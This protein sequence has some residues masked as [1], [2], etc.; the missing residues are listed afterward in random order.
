MFSKTLAGA[1][2]AALVGLATAATAAEAQVPITVTSS[3]N[4]GPGT[5]RAAINEANSNFSRSWIDFSLPAV[6]GTVITPAN[7][8]PAITSPL[9]IDG[10]TQPGASPAS[11]TAG[12]QPGVLIDAVNTTRALEITTGAS[13]IRGLA[14]HDSSGAAGGPDGIQITGNGN[15]IAGNHI[16]TDRT[17]IAMNF[18]NLTTGVDITG[19]RNTVGGSGPENANV[20]AAI[21]GDG[22]A[23]A[24]NRN[25]VVGNRLG[26]PYKGGLG[27]SSS[28]VSVT[29][30]ENRIGSLNT[31]HRN[32]ISKNS[33]D[34]VAIAGNRNIVEGNYVGL[35]ETGANGAG[36]NGDGVNVV[37]NENVVHGNTASDNSHG[38]FLDGTANTV[39]FNALGTNAK[40]TAAVPNFD[41]VRVWAGNFNVIGGADVSARNVISGN[42]DDGVEIMAGQANR[43]EGNRIGTN[44]DGVASLPNGNGVV[45]E[46]GFS[47]I[48]DNLVSGNT[49]AGVKL[50]GLGF[51]PPPTG[52]V[53]DGNEVAD[54]G[55][56][57][58]VEDSHNNAI[59]G[60]QISANLADGVLIEAVNLPNANGN[61]LTGNKIADNGLSGVRVKDADENLVGQPDHQVNTITGNGEDGVTVE[62]G[63]DNAVANNSISDN[64]DLGIDL[65]ADGAT[66]NDVL[67]DL[68]PGPNG[69]QNHPT[70]SGRSLV[71]ERL[72]ELPFV[73]SY[74]VVS[75]TLRSAASTDYRVELY[76][77]DA[78]DASG[79]GEAPELVATEQV[80][81][82]ATGLATGSVR[83]ET[84]SVSP[85]IAATATV[86]D[87]N[88]VVLGAS[89]ELSPCG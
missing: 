40:M 8:L 3:A 65:A 34:G 68:D 71:F 31:G 63:Q 67:L 87:P 75:W 41:G 49:S 29:G 30:N 35:D 88:G 16:G 5:L 27:N 81:T 74:T 23:I 52:N 82:D 64:G 80:T 89:S 20:I 9:E 79:R 57:V 69:L 37:G 44:G 76:G 10:Y 21:D 7:D 73:K 62:T 86:T 47:V 66:N 22:V 11:S 43:V 48:V 17:G 1:V 61:W 32:V 15:R 56:G 55:N 12:A 70:I 26:L 36:N 54:N 2:A 14:I 6:A 13:V 85:S 50:D 33:G 60:N 25:V 18:P 19:Q 84:A 28:G 46:T 72:D 45:V 39:T 83:F 42:T 78:C 38:V 59:T 4:A 24:A 77:A 58:V 53:V 51:G